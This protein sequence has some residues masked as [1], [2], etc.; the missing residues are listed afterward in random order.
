MSRWKYKT[1]LV[2][3]GENSQKVRML[4]AGE[5]K[6]F[7]DASQKIQ[8]GEF[9]KNSLPGMV[10][11]FGAIEPELTDDDVASMPPDLQEA[12]VTKILQLTGIG[13]ADGEKKEPTPSH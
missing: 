6:A 7:A 4:T 5:R 3:V 10:V 1:E 9:D 11:K 8:K 12:C 2:T 13:K